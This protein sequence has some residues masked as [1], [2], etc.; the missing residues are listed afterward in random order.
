MR[1]GFICHLILCSTCLYFTLQMFAKEALLSIA[2]YSFDVSDVVSVIFLSLII[3][4]LALYFS[5][6]RIIN[7]VC[8]PNG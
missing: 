4:M 8:Q 7:Y 1:E 3:C 2:L 5:N 6:P